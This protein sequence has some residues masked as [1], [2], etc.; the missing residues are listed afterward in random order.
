VYSGSGKTQSNQYIVDSGTTLVY[1]PTSAARAVNNLFSPKAQ[2]SSSQGAYFVNCN[3]KAPAFGVEIGG[4]TFQV[5]A[6]DMIYQ[7]QTDPQTGLCLTGIQDG[8]SGPYILGDVFLQNVVA[9][10]DVGAAQMR[11]AAHSY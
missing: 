1:L 2:F 3:A 5:N 8:G 9:V 4:T 6:A 10:F 11:F 7:N